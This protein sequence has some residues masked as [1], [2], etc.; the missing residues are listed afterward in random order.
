MTGG[1]TSRNQWFP[2]IRFSYGGLMFS[3]M[4][5]AGSVLGVAALNVCW[6]RSGQKWRNKPGA[7]QLLRG[8]QLVLVYS[9]LTQ[10]WKRKKP[11]PW[12]QLEWR[13]TWGCRPWNQSNELKLGQKAQGSFLFSKTRCTL[14]I[15]KLNFASQGY[16]PAISRRLTWI[17][18]LFQLESTNL[19]MLIKLAN[20]TKLLT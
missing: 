5:V 3:K 12:K 19:Q 6:N 16:L 4:S 7:C 1:A 14:W 10:L 11:C 20:V 18:K 13:Q 17:T 15:W 9:S 8:E 2:F